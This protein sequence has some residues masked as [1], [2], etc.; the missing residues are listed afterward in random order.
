MTPSGFTVDDSPPFEKDASVHVIKWEVNGG[1]RVRVQPPE[2]PGETRITFCSF[3]VAVETIKTLL[4]DGQVRAWVNDDNFSLTASQAAVVEDV[5]RQK[6]LDAV[7]A[8]AAGFLPET[9]RR[10]KESL[11]EGRPASGAPAWGDE[12]RAWFAA[13][14]RRAAA[15]GRAA[16]D[17]LWETPFLTDASGRALSPAALKSGLASGGQAAYS[18]V[19]T[20]AARLPRPVAYCPDKEDR[21]LLEA[22]FPGSLHDAT[23]LI[24]SLTHLK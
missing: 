5:R 23:Q 10:F 17:I 6:A 2:D 11:A 8:A 16:P 21:A 4:P 7:G 24:E 22:L 3:G 12:A 18:T 13:A 19:R 15:E 20:S 1:L 14:L 9:A